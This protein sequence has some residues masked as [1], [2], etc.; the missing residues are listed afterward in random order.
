MLLWLGFAVLT[1]GVVA[2]LLRPLLV[3]TPT[4]TSL[5]PTGTAVYRDQLA[6]IEADRARGLI[7]ET[8]AEAARVEIARRLLATADATTDA[9]GTAAPRELRTVATV[10]AAALPSGHRCL[11]RRRSAQ[12]AGPAVRG[13]RAG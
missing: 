7:A 4:D 12:S 8:E 5:Q 2:A 1:A 6:E 13:S 10:V 11:S 3:G 9:P